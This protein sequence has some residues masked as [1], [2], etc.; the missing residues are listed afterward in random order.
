VVPLVKGVGDFPAR[1]EQV[2]IDRSSA[3]VI[4]HTTVGGKVQERKEGRKGDVL[5][6]FQVND[7]ESIAL[8]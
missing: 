8:L 7:S 3:S 1:K 6:T 5:C 4:R 2:E